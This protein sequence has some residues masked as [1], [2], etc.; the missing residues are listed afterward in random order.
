MPSLSE[1]QFTPSAT[2]RLFFATAAAAWTAL[3]VVIALIVWL[4]RIESAQKP[5][6]VMSEINA[7]VGAEFF[8]RN[9]LLVWLG[10]SPHEAEK[11]ATMTAMPGQPQL[12]ADPFTVLDINAVPPVTRTAGGKETEWGLTLAATLISPGSGTNARNYFRVT[13]VEAGGTYKALMWPRPVNNSARAV[14]ISSYYTNG[15]AANTPLGTQVGAFLTAFYTGN[16]AGSLGSYVS[17]EFTDSA[18]KGSPYTSVQITSIM[19]AKDS[20]DTATAQPGTTVHVLATAKAAVSTTTFNTIDAPLRLTLSNN[21]QWLV[22]GF[23][24]PV[25]F[26]DVTYK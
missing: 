18:I 26:G 4:I 7:Y 17:S 21:K 16:N 11:L 22:D 15:I 20:P 23:D 12:N 8:A 5:V 25:H 10:G 2:R 9:F 14:Q 19:A 13:F 3:L 24:E 1:I 6:D